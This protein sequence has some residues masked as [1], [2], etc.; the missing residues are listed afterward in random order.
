MGLFTKAAAAMA[1]RIVTARRSESYGS[2]SPVNEEDSGN[3][4][5]HEPTTR[6]GK[7]P[8]LL[9]DERTPLI[10]AEESEPA[11]HGL[12]HDDDEASEDD[13]IMLPDSE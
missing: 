5:L 8:A 2:L 11:R 7:Q 6:A 12:I 9:P 4:L 3:Q 13:S 1:S 10:T